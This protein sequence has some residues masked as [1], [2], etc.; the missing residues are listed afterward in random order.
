VKKKLKGNR[1]LS[2]TGS[3]AEKDDFTST[4]RR[5]RTLC[6]DAT[7]RRCD[8]NGLRVF[9]KSKMVLFLISKIY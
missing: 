3:A 5:I 7:K 6:V 9:T 4:G 8:N 2:G 1:W